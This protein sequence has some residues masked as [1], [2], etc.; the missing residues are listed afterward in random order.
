MLPVNGGLSVR[1]AG[2]AT[3]MVRG[4]EPERLSRDDHSGRQGQCSRYRVGFGLRCGCFVDLDLE[5]PGL[6]LGPS[7]L[8]SRFGRG[9]GGVRNRQRNSSSLR[10]AA[11]ASV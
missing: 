4:R 2:T 3:L 11:S 6:A 5:G 7:L 1:R 10:R 9:C 8:R